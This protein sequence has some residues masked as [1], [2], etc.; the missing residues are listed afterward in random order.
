[1][2]L[3]PPGAK[4]LTAS[5]EAST[6]LSVGVELPMELRFRHLLHRCEAV[7]TGIVDED[8]GR[9]ESGFRLGKEPLHVGEFADI[10]LDCHGLA[11]TAQ[12]VADHA[13]RVP[14]A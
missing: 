9:S 6:V 14:K 2:I 1:M 10:R 13:A 7:H 3:P 11:A 8:A 5:C 4:A 12:N